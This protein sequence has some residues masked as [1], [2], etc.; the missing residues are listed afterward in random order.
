M[1]L[2]TPF[3]LY[4]FWLTAWFHIASEAAQGKF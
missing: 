2:Y 3:F 1:N 4:H